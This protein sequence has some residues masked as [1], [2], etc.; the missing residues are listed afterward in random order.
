M[1]NSIDIIGN[2]TRDLPTCSAVS[3][4]TALPAACT[5]VYVY[6]YIYI[7]TYTYPHVYV[8]IY[9]YTHTHIHTRKPLQKQFQLL[10]LQVNN[11]LS[12]PE[13]KH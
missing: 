2:R 10:C 3:Q 12:A 7:H 13:V 6:T 8:Y 9:I 4:P 1:K 5:H 11:L